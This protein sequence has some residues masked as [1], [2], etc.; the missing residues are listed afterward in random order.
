MA[1]FERHLSAE[2]RRSGEAGDEAQLFLHSLYFIAVYF[3]NG[4][5]GGRARPGATTG[6]RTTPGPPRL[7]PPRSKLAPDPPIT[8][9][10]R[11]GLV[12]GPYWP[13]SDHAAT[14][15]SRSRPAARSGMPD[16]GG[17]GR[18]GLGL[19]NGVVFTVFGTGVM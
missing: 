16:W 15:R 18:E 2:R 1:S 12:G 7:A 11:G 13:G 19:C 8:H 14:N 9:R 17:G 6:D 10:G 4:R 5:S 3:L